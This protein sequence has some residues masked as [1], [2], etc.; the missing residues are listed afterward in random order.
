MVP[1]ECD[2]MLTKVF[3]KIECNASS[4]LDISMLAGRQKCSSFKI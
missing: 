4:G 3:G 1:N 2:F